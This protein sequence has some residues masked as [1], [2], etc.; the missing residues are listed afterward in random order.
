MN[1]FRRLQWLICF[2]IQSTITEDD[3]ENFSGNITRPTVRC[4]LKTFPNEWSRIY[5]YIYLGILEW[6]PLNGV[7]KRLGQ[8]LF[9]DLRS[10]VYSYSWNTWSSSIIICNVMIIIFDLHMFSCHFCIFFILVSVS[11]TG[12]TLLL[13]R[14]GLKK[15]IEK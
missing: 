9:I 2:I 10:W 3:W 5:V 7:G 11:T 6:G 12:T 13:S 15:N 4:G 1:S 14:G 8:G